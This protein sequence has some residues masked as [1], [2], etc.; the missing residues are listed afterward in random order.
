[1]QIAARAVAC[2]AIAAASGALPLSAAAQID[3]FESLF[4]DLPREPAALADTIIEDVVEIRGLEFQRGIAVSNQTQAEFE[5]YLAAEMGRALPPERADVFGR[6]VN[7]LGLFKGPIIEDAAEM[8][9]MLATSQAAAYYDPDQSAFFVLLGDVP[10][11]MLAPIYAHELYHGLQDQYWDLDA[12]LL[13]GLE[14]GLNDDELLARQAV[15]EGEATYVMTLWMMRELT[16]EIPRGFALDLAVQ[17]QAQLDS[18][19]LRQLAVSG[20]VP[21]TGNE[22]IDASIAAMDEIPQFMMETLIGVYLKGMGFVHQVVKQGWDRGETLYT[23]PPRSTEQ[24]LHP[25]KWLLERDDPVAIEMPDPDRSEALEGW[26][27]LDS[28]V[29]GE[30]QLRIVFNEFE[31]SDRSTAAA[32]GW[33]GDR[34]AVLERGDDLLL[35]LYTAWDSEAEAEEFASAYEELL[36][37]KYPDGSETTAVSVR[38]ADVLIVEGGEPGETAGFMR[39]LASATRSD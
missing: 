14:D 32:A 36:T 5:Q 11:E 38:G 6:V 9:I 17:M 4:S 28:N 39:Y 29:L 12:Y 30:F 2:V 34:F 22:N 25:E 33:D 16:G 23:D 27:L 37:R 7:R 35:L 1:M 20:A 21:G 18:A 31:M 10:M 13:D 19:A 15:V 26:T 8:M 24:I 3:L